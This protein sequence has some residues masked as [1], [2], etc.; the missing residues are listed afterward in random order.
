MIES[1]LP[2]WRLA[3]KS[4]IQKEGK[5]FSKTWIQIATTSKDNKPRV[6][7][8]V[9]RG[10]LNAD[11]IL[12]YTDRRSEKIKHIDNNNDVELLWLFLK[13]K[14]QYRFKGKAYEIKDN[15]KFWNNLSTNSKKTWFWP[16]PGEKL[17]KKIFYNSPKNLNIPETFTVL[18][19]RI[20][21]VELLKLERPIHK[22][23]SWCKQ[24][25]WERVKLNP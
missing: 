7:S 20:N 24:E 4:S 15:H 3:I 16:N 21:H 19:V 22:R 11:S 9:F 1:R 23:C 8:V 17:A 6:R 25:G 14:S 13:S 10:W 2:E 18:E 5:S 12:I